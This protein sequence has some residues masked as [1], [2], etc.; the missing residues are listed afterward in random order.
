[1][2]VPP[3]SATRPYWSNENRTTTR[4]TT[5]TPS[6]A[7]LL[8]TLPHQLKRGVCRA[9]NPHQVP[10]SVSHGGRHMGFR[11]ASRRGGRRGLVVRRRAFLFR[12]VAEHIHVAATRMHVTASKQVK[13]LQVLP[14]TIS[15]PRESIRLRAYDQHRTTIMPCMQVDMPR[16]GGW[17]SKSL[18]RAAAVRL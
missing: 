7:G 12:R 8:R 1:M 5:I 15:A 2:S 18:T 14:G 3:A 6:P 17:C 16:R 9:V 4:M 10:G 11:V 13:S